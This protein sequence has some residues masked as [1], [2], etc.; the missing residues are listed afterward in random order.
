[1]LR[2][3]DAQAA[4]PASYAAADA[5][6]RW[7]WRAASGALAGVLV[8]LLIVHFGWGARGLIA[9]FTA[10]VL[11]ALAVIDLER[12]IIPNRIVL[13]ATA[14]VLAAQLAAYPHHAIEW[15]AASG[16]TAL[17]LLMPGLMR[18][19]ALGMGDVKLGL[20][21]G[22]ALGRHVITALL[23]GFFALWPL[24]F[25]LFLRHG[26]AAARKTAVPLGPFLAAGAIVALF[27]T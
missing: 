26:A 4:A 7:T 19:G 17:F 22:A 2:S 8:P 5:P 16:G 23:I 6:V 27:L 12:R 13:P 14:I 15:I 3:P 20:L 21:L 1:L 9:A 24:A 11:V 18:P 25:F 10:C